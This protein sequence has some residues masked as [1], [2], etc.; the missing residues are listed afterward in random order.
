[1]KRLVVIDGKSVYYRGYYAMGNLSK[2]DG[3]PTGGIYGFAAIAMEI[4]K[5]LQPDKVA[6]AWDKAGTSIAKRK[7][8]YDGY[9]A[10]RV[11]PPEDFYAQIPDL[12]KLIEALGWEFLERDEYEADDIIGSLAYQADCETFL[13]DISSSATAGLGGQGEKLSPSSL[14]AA[15]SNYL[16]RNASDV[17]KLNFLAKNASES[18][19]KSDLEDDSEKLGEKMDLTGVNTEKPENW[20][21]I[22][23]SSD[24]DMLQIVDEN[25][26]M[27]R[28]L[29][30]FS[31]IEEVDVKAIEEKY[32]ILKSQFLDLKALKGDASDNIP[33]VKGIGEKTAVK[34]LNEYGSIEGIYEHLEE[35]QGRTRKLLMEGKE[36][37]EMS[38]KLG[39]I[40]F[41]APV[42]LS[43]VRWLKY[44]SGKIIETLK[45]LE[46][47]SLIRKYQKILESGNGLGEDVI[48]KN[49][50]AIGKD[51][52][53]D[54][55]F[56]NDNGKN[57]SHNGKI[58]DGSGLVESDN[59]K[60]VEIEIP[61]DTE[62]VWRVKE[63]MYEDAEFR[64]K[65]LTGRKFYDLEQGK[66]LLNP[67]MRKG[68]TD[69]ELR[70]MM[71]NF[72][73]E[74]EMREYQRQMEEFQKEPKVYEV[75]TKLDFP[76]IPVL[77]RMEQ[78]GMMI[79]RE[80][81]RKLEEEYQK[82]NEELLSEIYRVTGEEFNVNSP[83]QL[84]E[85]LF[86]RIGLPTKGIKKTTRG[87]STGAK[88][89]EKL[90]KMGENSEES[91]KFLIITLIMKYR[92]VAKLLSTYIL[93]LPAMADEEGRI[94]TTFTQDVTAT[95]RLSSMNPN[96]QN[97]PA[98]TE[99]GRRIRAGFVAPEG[100][101]IVSADYAQFELRLAAAMAGD[102][103]LVAD[104]NAG[105]D[106]H[107]KTAADAFHVEFG[108]VTEA[109]RR[110]A[111][112]IN[113]GILYGMSVK[114]LADA[115][116][117]EFYEANKFMENYFMARH[118]I[119]EYMDEILRQAREEGFVETMYG[120]R[121]PTPDVKSPNFLVRTT[122]ERAAQNMPI[123]GTEADL[124][125]KAMIRISQ[126][127]PTG[128]EMIMQVH[129]SVM[130]ECGTE[131]VSEV[132]GIL[133]KVMEEVEPRLGV[134]LEVEVKIGEKW[135]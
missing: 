53:G 76:M 10:G 27:Y 33:G 118:K 87:Y 69:G 110:A 5:N 29:K 127:L 91:E 34:L 134:R 35:I 125:K 48:G 18:G 128:A 51:E 38:Y 72:S 79:S 135:E 31:E 37:A 119:R 15:S 108:E 25:T 39:K 132:S 94:H 120:R 88:E 57:E 85:V 66:F 45:Y 77:F 95:G 81:F 104:F 114:G 111:K 42:K 121:R 123:Q 105:I 59:G 71:F 6:V 24:L 8:I 78:A 56:E 55:F 2:S 44:D 101:R 130:V 80:H 32:G 9:K 41:D 113:F 83:I 70:Q 89:L 96:L 26:K 30:G 60:N 36:S 129:D 23:V 131:Q 93:P 21:T 67:L 40:M 122:A 99:E 103:E 102:E 92:E 22:I 61:E 64:E 58:E 75:M 112:V 11:K 13:T 100:R 17:E 46:F 98:R 82:K 124:M 84:S 14:L 3:T 107:R 52:N 19:L 68:K 126:E 20:E 47:N 4:V 109:Q 115:A 50:N 7:A 43:E 63:K 16:A 90:M 117:M 54:G 133:K 73:G 12:M 28:L 1:M 86:E 49:K 116:E 97:I 65:I 62:I 74:D 106:I